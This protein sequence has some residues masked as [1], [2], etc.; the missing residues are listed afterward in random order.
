VDDLERIELS[1]VRDFLRSCAVR[2]WRTRS[3]SLRY[4]VAA[5]SLRRGWGLSFRSE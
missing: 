5:M 4:P 3:T 1:A 2:T